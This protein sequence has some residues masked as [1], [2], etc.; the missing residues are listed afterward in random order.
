MHHGFDPAALETFA[1]YYS[2]HNIWLQDEAR[3]DEGQ[4]V[5]SSRL[6]PDGNVKKT[7]Y[8]G[9]WLRP[10][11]IFYS[12]AAV[13]E[14][15]MNRSVNV[16]VVRS[17]RAGPY[18]DAELALMRELMPHLQAGIALHRRLHQ[19]QVLSGA[20]VEAL[21]CIPSGVILLDGGG[22]VIHATRR[23]LK[24]LDGSRALSCVAGQP[25]SCLRAAD[26]ALLQ[27]LIHH[28]C[29]AGTGNRIQADA[30]GSMRLNRGDLSHLQ[31]LLTPLP[32]RSLPFGVSGAAAVFLS[33]ASNRLHDLSAALRRVY[34][35][36]EA[37]AR[38]TEALVGGSTLQ[39][40]A[41]ARQLSINTVRTQIKAA[42]AK[43]GVSRQSDLIRL[44]LTG[45]AALA[46]PR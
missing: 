19:L 43:A 21:E 17:E 12:A 11:E 38:L 42:A 34:R 18:S 28:A 9:D 26:D 2:Q 33:D 23:A 16:T 8:W 29:G 14:K 6:F 4:V 45:P 13:V 10:Q 5:V 36:T 24:M 30:H 27:K 41:D 7:E 3:H 31:L 22:Q 44:V 37:E 1:E 32:A 15:R 46:P 20:A 40:Y 39:E 25:L 35:M